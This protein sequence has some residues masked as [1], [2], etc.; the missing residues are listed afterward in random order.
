MEN[1]VEKNR[2]DMFIV[3]K[4]MYIIVYLQPVI[5]NQYLPK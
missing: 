2:L 5:Q 3:K 1:T 4:I